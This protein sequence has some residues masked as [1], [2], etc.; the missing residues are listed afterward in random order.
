MKLRLKEN[1]RDWRVFG[2]SLAASLTL[3]LTFLAWRGALRPALAAS[4]ALAPAALVFLAAAAP[5][6]LRPVYRAG[7]RAGFALG[8]VMGRVLLTLLFV[9]VVTP[10]G[11]LL[12][13]LG[14]DLLRLRRP[15]RD[16]T[17]WQP[18]RRR[19]ELDRLF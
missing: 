5:R 10:L 12:R 6:A 17:C 11:L 7:M 1:P 16:D 8:L 2:L 14:K 3:V 9:G 15:R 13:A 19:S 18:A 4:L